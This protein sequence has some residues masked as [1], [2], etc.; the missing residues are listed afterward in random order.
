MNPNNFMFNISHGC[1]CKV[2]QPRRLE[3]ETPTCRS[4]QQHSI[5]TPSDEIPVVAPTSVGFAGT[6]VVIRTSAIF[7]ASR[8]GPVQYGLLVRRK[9]RRSLLRLVRDRGGTHNPGRA[10]VV[11][12]LGVT[13]RCIVLLAPK[14]SVHTYRGH[15]AGRWAKQLQFGVG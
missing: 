14:C 4:N 8:G 15:A 11:L 3:H 13:K 10:K 7:L 2:H 5:H 9:M 12:S 1:C 6:A